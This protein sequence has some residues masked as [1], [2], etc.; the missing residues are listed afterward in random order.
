M[1]RSHDRLATEKLVEVSTK[2]KL[3]LYEDRFQYTLPV[4]TVATQVIQK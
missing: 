2:S 1:T 3:T 4:I